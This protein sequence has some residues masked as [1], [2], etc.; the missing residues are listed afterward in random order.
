MSTHRPTRRRFLKGAL[1]FGLGV[2]GADRAVAQEL[3]PTPACHDGDAPTVK[4]TEGPFFKPRSPERGDL[5]E[6]GLVGRPVALAGTVL[7]RSCRPVARALVDVWHADD[8]GD[9]DNKGFR[10][11]GHVFTDGEGRYAFRTI[12][13]GLYPGR[14]RHYHVKVQAPGQKV[15]TTQYYFPDEPRNRTDGLF[16][17]ALVMRVAEDGDGLAARFDVVLDM[18]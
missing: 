1:T 5:R 18:R 15:L 14:T 7:T 2:A 16:H 10:L 4:Q 13:P 11:R 8:A 12:L 17:R 6:P 3:P 9:Y